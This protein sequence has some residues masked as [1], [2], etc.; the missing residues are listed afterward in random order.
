MKTKKS[1]KLKTKQSFKFETG[2]IYLLD[3]EVKLDKEL[4]FITY[5]RGT[6]VKFIEKND[7]KTVTVMDS[8]NETFSVFVDELNKNKADELINKK[9]RFYFWFIKAYDSLEITREI[10][11]ALAGICFILFLIIVLNEYFSFLVWPLLALG[12]TLLFLA[13]A[14]FFLPC[15]T[16]Y[17]SDYVTYDTVKYFFSNEK[18]NMRE[19][20]K[21]KS[22]Y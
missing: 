10:S 15:F 21:L 12:V 1:K 22:K 19:F 14:I 17:P 20:K 18:E 5:E 7:G 4:E 2:E 11:L 13:I 8:Y 16:S 3:K 9:T 6:P